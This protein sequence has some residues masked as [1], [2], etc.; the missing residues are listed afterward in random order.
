MTHTYDLLNENLD[1]LKSSTDQDNNPL[2]IVE[3]EMSKKRFI[4]GR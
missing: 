2:K 3:V 1:I 4:P